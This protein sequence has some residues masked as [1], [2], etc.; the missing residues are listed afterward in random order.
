VSVTFRVS[1]GCEPRSHLPWDTVWDAKT[2]QGDWAL[3]GPSETLNRGGLRAKAAIASAVELALFTDRRCPSDHPLARLIDG[4]ARGWW[5]NGVDLREDLGETEL[6]SLLWLL[7][8]APLT[9]DSARWAKAM[10]EEAL[11]P[12]VAQGAAARIEVTTETRRD[13]SR[14]DIAVAVYARDGARIYDRKFD[15]LWQQVR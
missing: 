14:L 10:A 15:L 4:D 6:G 11:A 12:L 2:G 13:Q 7:E 1:E 5:G 8:Q 3:A 9:D